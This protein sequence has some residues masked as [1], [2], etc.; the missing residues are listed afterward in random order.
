MKKMI[1]LLILM[2][3]SLSGGLIWAKCDYITA[4]RLL[5]KE[6]LQEERLLFRT[7]EYSELLK[8]VK[9]LKDDE[10]L[11]RVVALIDKAISGYSFAYDIKTWDKDLGPAIIEDRSLLF[12]LLITNSI[13][14]RNVEERCL[15]AAEHLGRVKRDPTPIKWGNKLYVPPECREQYE[16]DD[17][18]FRYNEAIDIY[19]MYFAGAIDYPL[20]TVYQAKDKKEFGKFFEKLVELGEANDDERRAMIHVVDSELES[21]RNRKPSIFKYIDVEKR[22]PGVKKIK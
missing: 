7:K 4:K 3:L 11:D 20:W 18:I 1:K 21:E 6:A 14:N 10:E 5:S 12:R 15:K 8:Y 2:L 22:F 13:R 17:K 19:R 9:N 16:I